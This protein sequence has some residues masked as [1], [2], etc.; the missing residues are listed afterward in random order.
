MAS[1][2][3]QAQPRAPR[4]G[5]GE[6]RLRAALF[7]NLSSS[8]ARAMMPTVSRLAFGMSAATKSTPT[9]A[10]QPWLSVAGWK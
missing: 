7:L 3:D 4:L 6:R 1:H 5:G 10:P 8:A 2:H 9:S